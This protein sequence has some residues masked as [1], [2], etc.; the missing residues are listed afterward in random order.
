MPIL[1]YRADTSATLHDANEPD[2]SQNIYDYK[3]NQTLIKLGVPGKPGQMHPLTDPKRFYLNTQNTRVREISLP[4]RA[5]SYILVS[6]GRDGLYGT[7]DD[8]CNFDWQYR[9]R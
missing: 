8:I 2:N 9:E 4:Y 5:E 1:Y 7:A 3:D 6:A